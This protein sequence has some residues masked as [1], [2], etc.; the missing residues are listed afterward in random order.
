MRLIGADG[1]QVGV[2]SIREALRQA[3]EAELDLV[4]ISPDAAPPV[5]RIM[6]FG[7]FQ[8]ELNKQ[9]AQ[10][11]KK[12]KQIQIKEIKFRPGTDIGDYEIKRRKLI[13]FLEAGDK[14][15][16]TVRFRGREM[17]YQDLGVNLLD[18]IEKDLAQ[19]G[20]V[21]QRPKLEGRQLV[22]LIG[23]KKK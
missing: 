21:E 9:K 13:E 2:V 18:K 12:Q 15:K 3:E 1:K 11:R 20:T 6:D 7:K 22:M 16:I 23:P 19:H 14:V 4:E 8:F 10:Q 17:L 5:C